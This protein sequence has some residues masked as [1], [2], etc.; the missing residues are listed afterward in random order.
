MKTLTRLIVTSGLLFAYAASAQQATEQYIPIGQSPGLSDETVI[1][2]ITEVDADQH[3]VTVESDRGR[4]TVTLTKNTRYYLDS[5]H[6]GARNY[7]G[8]YEDCEVGRRVEV[9][10]D[11]D[12]NARWIKIATE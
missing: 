6:I 8:D 9:S 11:A 5:S 1:G 7:S 10:A 3:R 4:V 12:G 2:T